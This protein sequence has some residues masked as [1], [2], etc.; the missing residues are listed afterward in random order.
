[1]LSISLHV[2]YIDV[3][4]LVLA[5]YFKATHCEPNMFLFNT[6]FLSHTPK[7]TVPPESSWSTKTQSNSHAPFSTTSPSTSSRQWS[8]FW[9]DR[10]NWFRIPV[11]LLS[12]LCLS[13]RGAM[14]WARRILVFQT[15]Q[16]VHLLSKQDHRTG[17]TYI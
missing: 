10:P 3:C 2:Q 8:L 7:T 14:V 12:A 13:M 6:S 15:G 17:F 9:L 5:V 1:M 11:S 16:V 4:I